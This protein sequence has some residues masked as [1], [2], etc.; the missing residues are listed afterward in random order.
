MTEE[1]L[2]AWLVTVEGTP[3]PPLSSD[4]L[5]LFAR[6]LDAQPESHGASAGASLESRRL[7]ATMTFDAT[8]EQAAVRSA[9]NAY[10]SARLASRLPPAIDERFEIE[11]ASAEADEVDGTAKRYVARVDLEPEP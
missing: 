10:L 4:V 2:T 7:S 3:G 6:S 8:S 5:E 1:R 11:V 9:F